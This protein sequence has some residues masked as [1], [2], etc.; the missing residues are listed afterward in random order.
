MARAHVRVITVHPKLAF[1]GVSASALALETVDET[2]ER[3][4]RRLLD[5]ALADPGD[6]SIEG[7][8]ETGRPV[9]VLVGHSEE[10]DFL[11]A[12]SRGYEP[13]GAVLLGSTTCRASEVG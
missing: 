9:D 7:C 13:L 3:D 10:L 11:L 1:G 5:E 12:G 8:F 2:L 6:L 4:E